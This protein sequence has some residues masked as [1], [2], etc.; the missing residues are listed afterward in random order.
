MEVDYKLTYVRL[1]YTGETLE[2]V[3]FAFFVANA[4][5]ARNIFHGVLLPQWKCAAHSVKFS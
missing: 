3:T 5:V 2:G 1:V 4:N